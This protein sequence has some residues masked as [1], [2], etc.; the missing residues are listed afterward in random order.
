MTT[1][2]NEIIAQMERLLDEQRR[3]L[4]ALKYTLSVKPEGR[5]EVR[6]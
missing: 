1:D 3:D 2:T 6:P 5:S 4:A